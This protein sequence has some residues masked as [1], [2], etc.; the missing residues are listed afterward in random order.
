MFDVETQFVAKWD[1]TSA[2]NGLLIKS[3]GDN[4][5]VTIKFWS[6][7]AGP[8]GQIQ[9]QTRQA[10]MGPPDI[11][12]KDDLVILVMPYLLFVSKKKATPILHGIKQRKIRIGLILEKV[13]LP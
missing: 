7:D 5:W 11:L 10:G 13:I 12:W 9:Y 3:P 4:N 8:K 1:T 6:R 2:V